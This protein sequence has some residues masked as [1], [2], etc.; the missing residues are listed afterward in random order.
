M[1]LLP[2]LLEPFVQYAVHDELHEEPV[3]LLP[4]L[5]EP[6]LQYAVQEELHDE[7]VHPEFNAPSSSSFSSL[8]EN[9]TG[10][11]HTPTRKGKPLE[12][13]FLKNAL[14]DNISDLFLSIIANCCL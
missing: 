14:L 4:E 13:A 1:Q 2:E 5:L 9:N 11:A 10:D 3:Q 12:T 6:F 7:P 8:Q